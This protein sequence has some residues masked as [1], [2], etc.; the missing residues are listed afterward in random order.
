MFYSAGLTAQ[1]DIEKDW[2]FKNSKSLSELWELDDTH[3]RGTFIIT[4]YKP[5]YLSLAKFTTNTNKSPVNVN[6]DNFVNESIDSDPIE[7]KFQLSLK[8]KVFHDMLW[9]KADLWI[10]FSQRS[11]WQIYNQKL[12]RPFREINY[13]PEVILNFPVNYKLF[14]FE[15]K[16]LG[17]ALVH[18]SNGQSDPIS[19]SWNRISFHAG[20]E[21]DQW[22][23]M[24]KSWLRL[25][26]SNDDNPQILNYMGRGEAAITYDLGRQR[27]SAIARHSLRIGENGRGQ[28]STE[29]GFSHC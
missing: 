18:E 1:N 27:F 21:R 12:S 16:M 4:S 17:A 10:A 22:Q 15:G 24:L 20:F 5:I 13:E 28:P 25:P 23:V 19:R 26:T 6:S 2:I 3:H 8:T 7:A 29:L 14:G 11:Y 9:G